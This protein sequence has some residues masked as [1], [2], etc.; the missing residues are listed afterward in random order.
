MQQLLAGQRAPLYRSPQLVELS[1]KLEETEN[2]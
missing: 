1:F 2:G